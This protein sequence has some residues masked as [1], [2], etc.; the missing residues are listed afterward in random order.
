MNTVRNTPAHK[1]VVGVKSVVFFSANK[2]SFSRREGLVAVAFMM[3]V[4]FMEVMPVAVVMLMPLSDVVMLVNTTHIYTPFAVH[5]I[6]LKKRNSVH[7]NKTARPPSIVKIRSNAQKNIFIM[8][9]IWLLSI[10]Y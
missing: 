5:Y 8:K 2:H 10:I 6:I 3:F 7:E 4:S 9:I 1:S